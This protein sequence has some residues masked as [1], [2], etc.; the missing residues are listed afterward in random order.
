[1][2]LSTFQNH[3]GKPLPPDGPLFIDTC[4]RQRNA[5]AVDATDAVD[6]KDAT[7]A[8]NA[9]TSY[10]QSAS[11]PFPMDYVFT[12]AKTESDA[13]IKTVEMEWDGN[14]QNVSAK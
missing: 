10:R 6:A 8:G 2:L 4:R 12:C 13:D 5:D 14:N 3:L 9:L 1:M 11:P 7:V